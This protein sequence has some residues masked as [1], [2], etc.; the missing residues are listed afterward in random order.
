[1]K[2]TVAKKFSVTYNGDGNTGGTV[3]T[4]NTP[5]DD[6]DIVTVQ[7]EGDLEKSGFTFTNWKDQDDNAFNA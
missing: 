4:D 7:D 2:V 5:Y 3:P 1:L 6:G